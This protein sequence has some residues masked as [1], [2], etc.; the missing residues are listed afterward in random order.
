MQAWRLVRRRPP[1]RI[2]KSLAPHRYLEVLMGTWRSKG[3]D[4]LAFF[5]AA[6]VRPRST[7]F[8]RAGLQT[9]G[10]RKSESSPSYNTKP[11]KRDGGR[12]QVFLCSCS[13]VLEFTVSAL[14]GLPMWLE[15]GTQYTVLDQIRLT[16]HR[17]S[18]VR[19]RGRPRVL[20]TQLP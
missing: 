1:R 2:V 19:I 5:I 20:H 18:S 7:V 13:D 9:V 4:R 6:T 17:D 12:A 14:D 11:G 3:R 10:A 16:G 8:P 15:H